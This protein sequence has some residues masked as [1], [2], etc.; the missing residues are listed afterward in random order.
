[1]LSAI[2][3]GISNRI[4]IRNSSKRAILQL[5]IY[6]NPNLQ[7]AKELIEEIKTLRADNRQLSRRH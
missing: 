6:D 5:T 2:K 1:M 7:K 3:D 4:A